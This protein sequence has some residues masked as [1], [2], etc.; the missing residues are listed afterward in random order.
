MRKSRLSPYNYLDK[1]LTEVR[2]EGCFHLIC[3]LM[4]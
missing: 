4:T 1:Y 2:A 3:S